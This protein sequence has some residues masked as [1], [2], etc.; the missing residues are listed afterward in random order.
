MGRE[1]L[2]ALIPERDERK[3]E[4]KGSHAEGR[5]EREQERK[6][7]DWE[8]RSRVEAVGLISWLGSRV[9]T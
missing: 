9:V 2:R 3:R 4:G 5:R 8:V 7:E 6:G 1:V